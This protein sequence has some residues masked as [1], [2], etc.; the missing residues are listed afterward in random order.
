MAHA[1]API[2]AIPTFGTLKE[3]LYQSDYISRKKAQLVYC[4]SSSY[5]NK[6]TSASSYNQLNSYNLGSYINK[7]SSCNFIPVN[8]DN[9][10][11]VQYTK[12]NLKEVCTVTSGSP[13]LQPFTDCNSSD[14]SCVPSCNPAPVTINPLTDTVPFYISNTI[15]PLGQL[16]GLSQC[17]PLNY[18][19]KT[20][21]YPP[22]NNT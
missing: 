14:S 8:K 7:L 16:F 10:I 9:L 21:F 22:T 17:G 18:T 20:V 3:N 11:S 5:C 19:T 2:S 6:I 13:P 15:D 1:F 4:N 12:L